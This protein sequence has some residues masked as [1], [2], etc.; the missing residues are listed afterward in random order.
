[1]DSKCP[2]CGDRTSRHQIA[3]ADYDPVAPQLVGGIVLTLV[4][5]LSRKRR[6]RCDHCGAT[7]YAHTVASRIWLVAVSLLDHD[8]ALV[9]C[10]K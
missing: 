8:R 3:R 6:F 10:A 2:S 5:V 1:M 9:T 4:F 7:F